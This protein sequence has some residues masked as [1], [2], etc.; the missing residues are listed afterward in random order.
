MACSAPT[1]AAMLGCCGSP[2][3][4]SYQ[5]GMVRWIGIFRIDAGRQVLP[6]PY[7]TVTYGIAYTGHPEF[8]CTLT[9][10]VPAHTSKEVN[11]D[12]PA[13]QVIG[14][15]SS[16]GLDWL[17]F[18]E[19]KDHFFPASTWPP[20]TNF[21][22]PIYSPSAA[23]PTQKI[24]RQFTAPF[25]DPITGIAYET[26][27]RFLT[28]TLSDP[29]TPPKAAILTDLTG[30]AWGRG[31]YYFGDGTYETA[32]EHAFGSTP[33]DAAYWQ[34]NDAL[35]YGGWFDIQNF[36]GFRTS[37]PLIYTVSKNHNAGPGADVGLA[38]CQF[39]RSLRN[40]TTTNCVV[41]YAVLAN[42]TINPPASIVPDVCAP[43]VRPGPVLVEVYPGA[44]IFSQ[45]S[46]TVING[47]RPACCNVAP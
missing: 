22:P 1:G 46:R 43:N 7:R 41:K 18:T 29:F 35:H 37:Q 33:Q 34:Y 45:N 26:R 15:Q 31:H 32:G 4:D 38:T 25:V 28:E 27:E 42:P 11:P 21:D 19:L 23:F 13:T 3:A 39:N 10:T 8:D 6:V 44:S 40:K 17:L 5:S 30:R 16:A 24:T 12:P 47:N 2:Q 9:Y 14:N 20:V 36:Y